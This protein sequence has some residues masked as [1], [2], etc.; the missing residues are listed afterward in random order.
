MYSFLSLLVLAT[1]AAAA[2]QT[3][4]NEVQL[5]EATPTDAT[6]A[7]LTSYLQNLPEMPDVDPQAIYDALKNFDTEVAMNYVTTPFSR[8]TTVFKDVVLP[9]GIGNAYSDP[10]IN[11]LLKNTDLSTPMWNFMP[12]RSPHWGGQVCT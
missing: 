4:K 10:N 5:V 2:P 8:A 3:D 12:T 11:N 7:Y 6:M 1:L 9:Y